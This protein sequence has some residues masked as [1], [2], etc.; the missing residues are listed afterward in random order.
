MIPLIF[1][2]CSALAA[3][4]SFSLAP[5]SGAN[6]TIDSAGAAANV[7]LSGPLNGMGNQV[8][9]AHAAVPIPG[10]QS[11]ASDYSVAVG[12]HLSNVQNAG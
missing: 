12:L 8:V 11:G 1:F 6:L 4:D 9:D 3:D 5:W 7:A 2:G 10:S